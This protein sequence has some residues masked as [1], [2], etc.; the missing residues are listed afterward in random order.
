MQIPTKSKKRESFLSLLFFTLLDNTTKARTPNAKNLNKRQRMRRIRISGLTVL[1]SRAAAS[2]SSS[3]QWWEDIQGLASEAT[4]RKETGSSEKLA[5]LGCL[6]SYPCVQEHRGHKREKRWG[7]KERQLF[8][9]LSSLSA[10][11]SFSLY[12]AERREREGRR[13]DANPK[14]ADQKR[15]E[16]A[17]AAAPCTLC[18]ARTVHRHRCAGEHAVLVFV[19]QA[20]LVPHHR[21]EGAPATPTPISSLHESFKALVSQSRMACKPSRLASFTSEER[22]ETFAS[23]CLLLID[24][25]SSSFTLIPTLNS[26]IMAD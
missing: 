7:T 20:P 10:L 16:V 1:S 25:S 13:T 18:T 15:R 2:S 12:V 5:S 23:T 4:S 6:A 21:A 3:L 17:S 11:F 22:P 14:Y 26:A 9:H 8:L 19:R 24:S